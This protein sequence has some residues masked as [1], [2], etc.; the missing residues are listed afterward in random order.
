MKI[1]VLLRGYHQ[2]EKDRFGYPLDAR[3]FA[4]GLRRD[5]VDSLRPAHEVVFF[6]VTYPSGIQEELLALLKPDHVTVLESQ[7]STQISTFLRGLDAVRTHPNAP[8]DR[9]IITRFDL[10]FKRPAVEWDIWR[11]TG[12]FLPWRESEEA[13]RAHPVADPAADW[14]TRQRVGDIVHVIDWPYLAA[15]EAAV[16]SLAGQ[17]DLHNLYRALEKESAPVRF[18][19]PGFYDSNTLY[20]YPDCTNPLY[21]IGNRP[22][23]RF[24]R[25]SLPRWLNALTRCVP[26]PLWRA[27]RQ[28]TWR[29]LRRVAQR[30]S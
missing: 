18:I 16:A 5:L 30:R 2:L 14:L 3:E 11:E 24:Q 13:W 10:I 23:L 8:F 1:A 9:V 17:T 6:A 21:H 4:A 28:L 26:T 15:F 12:I 7:S 27:A 22:K 25:E 19:E 20:A 29:L